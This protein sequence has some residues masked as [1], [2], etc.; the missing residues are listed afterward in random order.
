MK[1]A[2]LQFRTILALADFHSVIGKDD[3]EIDYT[4]RIIKGTFEEADIELAI[5]GFKALVIEIP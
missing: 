3:H 4:N 2:V 1:N 5:A